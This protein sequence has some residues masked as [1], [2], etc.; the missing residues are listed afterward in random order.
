MPIEIDV[1]TSK[2]TCFVD[3]TRKVERA[4]RSASVND[5][6][7]CVYVPHTT[8]AV[9]IN[10]NAD[11]SVSEDIQKM[12]TELIPF[13]G[14]Y[15]HTEGNSAAHIK[16]S[17]VGSSELVMVENGEL[18]LGTWQGIFFCEFDGPRRR[19]LWIKALG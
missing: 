5:G 3:V 18:V 8:A 11:P 15:R 4:L 9:T 6:L 17:I 19:K 2:R 7:V 1:P 10:E 14:G 12:L 13:N 16:A